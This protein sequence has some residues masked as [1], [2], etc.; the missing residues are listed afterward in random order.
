MNSHHENVRYGFG[1]R[2]KAEFPSQV[3]VDTTEFCNL[4]CIHCP[5]PTFKKSEHYSGRN[6][7]PELNAKIIDEIRDYGKNITQY[8]RYT[9]R[10][11]PLIH[12]N[13]FE[14]LDYAVLHSGTTVTLTTNGTL[15]NQK[16]IER[17]LSTGVHLVDI[18]TDAYSDETYST[19]RV[20]G[21]LTVTRANILQLIQM[22]KEKGSKTKVVVSFIEQPVNSHEIKDFESFWKDNGA[23]YVVVRRLHS[24]AGAV[25]DAAENF[26]SQ[27]SSEKR[28]PCLY[29]WERIILNPRGELAFCPQDWVNGSVISDYRNSTVRDVWSGEFY[30][31]LRAAHLSNKLA[32]HKFCEQC[33]DWKATRWPDQGRS[34]ADMVEKFTDE[35]KEQR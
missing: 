34:Y 1:D 7:E 17:L 28:Y 14:M 22:S 18:S 33:P 3:I 8:V 12:S 15:L 27:N 29:P 5:H 31:N 32:N 9:G 4:A 25:V 23:D 21:D 20:N 11:E 35:L 6:L 19:V 24:G 2:L 13:F 30:R 16:K 26:R 10:G